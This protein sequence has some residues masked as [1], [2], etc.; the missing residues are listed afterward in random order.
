MWRQMQHK[1][2]LKRRVE[3]LK[4]EFSQLNNNTVI[5][6]NFW[7]QE[8]V[9]CSVCCK[10]I[11]YISGP[12]WSVTFSRSTYW[13]LTIQHQFRSLTSSPSGSEAF[14]S[15]LKYQQ[16]TFAQCLKWISS[17]TRNTFCGTWYLPHSRVHKSMIELCA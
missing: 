6:I 10:E 14:L 8:S 3:M 1:K 2:C 5:N 13:K 15:D 11:M 17:R 4:V 7:E 9:V 12:L 16:N